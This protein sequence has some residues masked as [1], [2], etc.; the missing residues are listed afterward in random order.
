MVKFLYGIIISLFVFIVSGCN[1]DNFTADNLR[2]ASSNDRQYNVYEIAISFSDPLHNDK[3]APLGGDRWNPSGENAAWWGGV[4]PNKYTLDIILPNPHES[5]DNTIYNFKATY[6]FRP[7]V[8]KPY[9]TMIKYDENYNMTSFFGGDYKEGNGSW[10]LTNTFASPVINGWQNYLTYKITIPSLFGD[11]SV[12][13]LI[14]Y[15][16]DDPL[17]VRDET[18]PIIY[19]EAVEAT[20]DGKDFAVKKKVQVEHYELGTGDIDNVRMQYF[21]DIVL[22]R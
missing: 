9:F 7:D 18:H 15:W 2:K 5:W 1:E 11:N 10:Y 19:P 3:V 14:V 22:D 4:D 13:D 12:H 17:N 21:L 20:F 16:G 8:N 6:G